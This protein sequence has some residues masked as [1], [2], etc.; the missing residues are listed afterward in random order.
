MITKFNAKWV[1]ERS[2]H[3]V[4]EQLQRHVDSIN[5]WKDKFKSVNRENIAL[6]AER[7][8]LKKAYNEQ[9]TGIKT[10]KKILDAIEDNVKDLNKEVHKQI[11]LRNLWFL[12]SIITTT[13]LIINLF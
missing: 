1:K 4:A 3:E 8:K 11:A 12:T 13:L 2:P 7:F 6:Q 9:K 5:S 10:L